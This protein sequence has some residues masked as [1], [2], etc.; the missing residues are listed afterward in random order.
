M[1]QRFALGGVA[2]ALKR[3]LMVQRKAE[4]CPQGLQR[5]TLLA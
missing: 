4:N 3:L 5:M 2:G 1:R